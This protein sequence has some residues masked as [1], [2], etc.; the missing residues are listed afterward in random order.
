MQDVLKYLKQRGEGLDAEIAA[1]T[2][3]PLAEVRRQMSELA[4]RGDVV[5]C[6]STR[7]IDGT[8]SEGMLCRIA[9]YT[10]HAAP[11]RKPSVK[12]HKEG[13]DHSGE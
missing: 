4:K 3:I 8:K 2:G 5:A 1:G 13:D 12:A 10:P 7:F 9:G 6:H 11:G